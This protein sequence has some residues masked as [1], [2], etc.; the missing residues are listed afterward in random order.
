MRI[1]LLYFLLLVSARA[2]SPLPTDEVM[3]VGRFGN[4]PVDQPVRVNAANFE[5]RFGTAD[6]TA[7]SAEMQ[8]RQYFRNGG[9]WLEVV[10]VD[11]ARPL[12]SALRGSFLPPRLSGAGWVLP[13]SDLGILLIPE[14]GE[15]AAAERDGLLESLRPLADSRH[16]ILLMDP[17]ASV[18][19]P[20]QASAWAAGLPQDLDFAALLYPHV[21][22]DPGLLVGTPGR[23][24]VAIGASGSTAPVVL[25]KD[26]SSGV[27]DAAAGTAAVLEVEDLETALTSGQSS[28]LNSENICTLLDHSTHGILLWGWRSRDTSDPENRYLNVARLRRWITH[29]LRRGLSGPVAT[30]ANQ[31]TLW[32]AIDTETESFLH[33]LFRNGAFAGETPS[34]AYFSACDSSTTTAADVAANRANL[35]FAFAPLSPANFQVVQLSFATA[36]PSRPVPTGT[37]LLTLPRDGTLR[38]FHSTAPG[39]THRME[40]STTLSVDDWIHLGSSFGDGGWRKTTQLL[41]AAPRFFRLRTQ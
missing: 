4:G 40:S 9:T 20:S 32:S 30:T 28:T 2:V 37:M 34:G 33:T 3:I 12:A 22:V 29:S 17:P 13:F 19:T 25:R 6:P 39:F 7:W 26:D 24:E 5:S 11:P 16:F 8:A 41:P 1:F 18:V 27:W 38:L 15:L 31:P 21:M 23:P 14:I 10:R 35:V 36:D